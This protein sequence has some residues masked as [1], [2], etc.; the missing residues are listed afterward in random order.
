M[1]F[2]VQVLRYVQY[3]YR[4]HRDTTRYLAKKEELYDVISLGYSVRVLMNH[5]EL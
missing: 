1:Q 5:F 3:G 4:V 2:K